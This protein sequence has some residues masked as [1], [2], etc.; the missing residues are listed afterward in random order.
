ME[1]YIVDGQPFDVAPHRLDDFLKKYPNASKVQ[2]VEKTIDVVEVDVPA[3]SQ[4]PPASETTEPKSTESKSEDTLLEL[5]GLLQTNY[6]FN[7]YES[8]IPA[9][10]DRNTVFN[11]SKDLYN[12]EL[13]NEQNQELVEVYKEKD[14]IADDK[15]VIDVTPLTETVVEYEGSGTALTQVENEKEVGNNTTYKNINRKTIYK[16]VG[17]D[18]VVYNYTDSEDAVT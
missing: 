6:N 4:T 7:P 16:N 5:P 1:R 18:E 17:E 8:V 3:T 10:Q 13:I 9:V 12:I 11:V 14:E 15:P 2:D